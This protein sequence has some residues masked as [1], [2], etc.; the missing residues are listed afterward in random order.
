MIKQFRRFENPRFKSLETLL[1][2][3]IPELDWRKIFTFEDKEVGGEIPADTVFTP[4]AIQVLDEYFKMF[5]APGPCIRCGAKQGGDAIDNALGISKFT[6]GIRHGEG[7]CMDCMWP[8]RALHYDIGP[9]KR[10]EMILQ[11][12]PTRVKVNNGKA[13]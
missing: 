10:L 2:E 8:A 13:L 4:E 11:V 5:V 12:H 9:V 3:N 7:H 6:W 1:A